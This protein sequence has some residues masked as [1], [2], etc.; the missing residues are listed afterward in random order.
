[1]KVICIMKS[2][3]SFKRLKYQLRDE[4]IE[5]EEPL[6]SLEDIQERI[7]FAGYEVAIIDQNVWWNQEARELLENFQVEIIPFEGVFEEV[8]NQILEMLPPIV[9]ESEEEEKAEEVID[10]RPIRYI[11]KEKI[12]EK[13]VKIKVPEYKTVFANIPTKLIIIANLSKRAGSTFLTLNLAKSLANNKILTG[14][15][16]PPLDRPYIFDTINLE[17]RLNKTEDEESLQFY[18]YPHEIIS[19]NKIIANRETIEDG[20]VWNVPDPRKPLIEPGDWK[21]EHMMKLLYT[22][23]RSNINLLDVG[24]HIFHESI[25]PIISESDMVILVVDPLP[26]EIMQNRDTKLEQL[27]KLKK[28]GLPIEIVVNRWN[29]GVDQNELNETLKIQPLTRLPSVQADFVY[30]MIY[31]NKI[32]LEHP[33][34]KKQLERHLSEIIKLII[35]AEY[36]K[37]ESTRS[38]KKRSL[39]SQFK[40]K[41]D[42]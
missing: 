17:D 24:E 27:M 33:E 5:L 22:T 10:N 31:K 18:S 40:K 34:V 15:I 32:P 6:Q 39:F 21:Y 29:K 16:E 26:T 7:I 35:P 14:V 38:N 13:E 23:K 28:Q 4:R 12:I 3:E 41:R 37:E 1:M 8:T 36:L 20:I 19:G 25:S 11:E 42:D 30:E 9:E 2:Q